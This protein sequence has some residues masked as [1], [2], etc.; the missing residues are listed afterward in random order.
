MSLVQKRTFSIFYYI[1]IMYFAGE[2]SQMGNN[3]S[4][5]A[6]IAAFGLALAFTISCSN[7]SGSGNNKKVKK[8]KISGVSQKGPFVKG[9]T[10]KIY[11]LDESM[12]ETGN[13]PFE[14]K[15][16]ANGNFQIEITNG[17][18][19]SQY[20]VL[21]VSGN[22]VSEVSGKQSTVPITLKAVADVSNKNSVN[23]NVLTHLEC[24]KVLELAK[25]GA[26]FE[27]AKKAVQKEVLNALGISETGIGNEPVL[28][29]V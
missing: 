15:T 12:N 4:K 29:S 11:E 2:N 25:S 27:D 21:E 3:L 16:D 22:Y 14:G 28:K 10:V 20:I 9:T 18:L 6:L 1:D 8:E 17:G 13:L 26:K 24:D 19:I 5:I 23:I 7:D